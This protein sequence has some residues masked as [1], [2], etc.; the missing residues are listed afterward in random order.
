MHPD[1]QE[2]LKKRV[3]AAAEVALAHRHYVS[4]IDVLTGA[5]MLTRENGES[6][7]KGRID[8]LERVMQGNLKQISKSMSFFR[9]WAQQK[10][11]KPSHTQYVGRTRWGKADLQFSKSGDHSI[12]K[13]YRTHYVSP[14]LSQRKQERLTQKKSRSDQP[15]ISEKPGEF[16]QGS[17]P[18][19]EW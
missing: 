10:G 16:G 18:F 4:A 13:S 17:F 3:V 12:E 1:R 2:P 6:W 9:Q 5:G 15:V 7:R 14:A 8:F 19:L 11:L